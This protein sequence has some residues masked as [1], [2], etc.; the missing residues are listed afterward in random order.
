MSEHG[1][2]IW[3]ELDTPDQ[4]VS[5][6]FFDKLLGWSRR[7]VNA[8]VFG[9]YTLFQKNGRDVAGMMNPTTD[10]ASKHSRWQAYIAVDDV[11]DC[12]RRVPELGGKVIVPAHDI[13]AFGRVCQV[14][15][16]LGAIVCLVTT[17]E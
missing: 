2:F 3:N 6:L 5:G 9:I 14:S 12:A 15:D 4:H 10:T 17:K 11:D 16:P 8:G 1:T 13:P 7:E